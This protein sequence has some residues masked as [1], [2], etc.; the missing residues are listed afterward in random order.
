MPILNPIFPKANRQSGSPIFPVLANKTG[1]RYISYSSFKRRIIPSP[2]IIA[3]RIIS[4][5]IRKILP[6][7]LRSTGNLDRED[8]IRQGVVMYITSSLIDTRSIFLYLLNANPTPITINTGRTI[9][10]ISV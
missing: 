5:D 8:T 2:I 9:F 1:G 6:A 7:I 10:R 3:V 4:V